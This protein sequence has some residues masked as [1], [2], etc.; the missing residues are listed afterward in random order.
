MQGYAKDKKI[1]SFDNGEESLLSLARRR[2]EKGRYTDALTVLHDCKRLHGMSSEL[3]EAYVDVYE[4]LDMYS[5]CADIWFEYYDYSDGDRE[6]LEDIYEGLI[7]SFMNMGREMESLI[8]YKKLIDEFPH[9]EVLNGFMDLPMQEIIKSKQVPPVR[10]VYPKS[11]EDYANDVSEGMNALRMNDINSA[12]R[13]FSRVDKASKHYL[14]AGNMLAI[15]HVFNGDA[16]KGEEM[17][18][19]ILAEHPDDVNTLATLSAMYNERGEIERSREIALKLCD[20]KPQNT[21]ELYK[22]ATVALEN[23]L[24]ELATLK[25]EELSVHLPADKSVAYFLAVA[26][27]NTG[28]YERS[29][30]TL[31]RITVLYP[32][33]AVAKYYL[34]ELNL[35]LDTVRSGERYERKRIPYVYRIDDG[36]RGV[37]VAL[38]KSLL[39]VSKSKMD[40]VKGELEEVLYWC[41]DE[42]DGNDIELQ[43]FAMKLAVKF[44]MEDFVKGILLKHEVNDAVKITALYELVMSNKES[45]YNVVVSNIIKR[46]YFPKIKLGRAKRTQFLSVAADLCSRYAFF[47]DETVYSICYSVEKFYKALAVEELYH[48]DYTREDLICAVY[49]YAD[50][51][52][53]QNDFNKTVKEF[54]ADTIRVRDLC[55]LVEGDEEED[56]LLADLSDEEFEKF[57]NEKLRGLKDDETF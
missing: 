35:A 9:S 12:I 29:R 32:E 19:E 56:D 8:Y 44:G 51:N 46:V 10:I 54:G 34:K 5:K 20:T 49:L 24:D 50:I 2:M 14:T 52:G 33:A 21:D 28:E 48:S 42:L 45:Y 15:C 17:C 38:L 16:Q 55:A 18:N 22:I 57:I 53:A 4:E 26:L 1:L 43:I 47:G 31:K 27:Y 13:A 30:D 25:L 7:V 36:K 40:G 37:H 6:Y 23:G 11:D 3:Y 41:F 39:K